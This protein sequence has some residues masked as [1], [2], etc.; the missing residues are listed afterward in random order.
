[1]FQHTR[2]LL[3]VLP[4]LR[5]K[6]LPELLTAGELVALYETIWQARELTHVIMLQLLLFTG[7]RNAE[8]VPRRLPDVNLVT[9]QPRITQGKGAKDRDVR[10]PTSFRG[11]LAQYIERQRMQGT[12][13]RFVSKRPQPCST[14]RL[15][16]IVK[17]YATAAGITKRVYP[18]LCRHQLLTHLTQQGIISPKLQLLSGHTTAQSLAVYR[19]LALSDV[20]E[21]Y[22]AAMRLFPVR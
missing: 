3:D 20:A 21:A 14:R 5:P 15:R 4:S 10:L 17:Q 19:A 1:V 13:Y 6:R 22:E 9:C 11:E 7:A 18:H 16:Q 12:T 8:L 2:T